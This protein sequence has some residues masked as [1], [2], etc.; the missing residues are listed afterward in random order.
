MTIQRLTSHY[1][2][3]AGGG[4]LAY[5]LANTGKRILLLDR[6]QYLPR[7]KAPTGTQN[8]CNVEGKYRHRSAVA[9][10]PMAKPFNPTSING[11]G[12]NTKVYG[13]AL[14]RMRPPG[15]WPSGAFLG[16]TSP[17]WPLLYD[18]FAPY[19]DTAEKL[20]WVHGQQGSDPLDP[21]RRGEFPFPPLPHEPMIH[22]VKDRLWRQGLRPF[23]LP[24]GIKPLVRPAHQKSLH[25][26]RYLRWVP[27]HGRCQGRCPGVLRRSGVA[28]RKCVADYRSGG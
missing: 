21:P 14:L 2:Y 27:L 28:P 23:S 11:W 26:L 25:S 1:C 18:D 15:L 6:G 12:G 16:G 8:R 4:T 24:M 22:S 3:R 19:Y 17:A 9:G 5:A 20:Y 10:R 7:E 13:A